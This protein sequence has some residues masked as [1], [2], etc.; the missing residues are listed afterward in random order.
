MARRSTE[1]RQ[2]TPVS[3]VCND[4]TPTGASTADKSTERER[5][6]R[7]RKKGRAAFLAKPL[8]RVRG[9]LGPAHT[10]DTVWTA[11]P[12]GQSVS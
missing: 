1:S 4:D 5:E 2:G 10:G 8:Q 12:E 11:R 9:C 7:G 3:D 6:Q